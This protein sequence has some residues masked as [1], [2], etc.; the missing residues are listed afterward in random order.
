[1]DVEVDHSKRDLTRIA[2]ADADV[3]AGDHAIDQIVR[4]R[5]AGLVVNGEPAQDRRVAKPALEALRWHLDEVQWHVQPGMLAVPGL[6]EHFVERVAELVKKRAHILPCP[7]RRLIAHGRRKIADD[8]GD[9][10]LVAALGELAAADELKGREVRVLARPRMQVEVDGAQRAPSGRIANPRDLHV[11]GPFVDGSLDDDV[12][13]ERPF[14]QIEDPAQQGLLR[15]VLSHDL[16]VDGI[17]ALEHQIEII[18]DV[19]V[20]EIFD[21]K[22]GIVEFLAGDVTQPE[23]LGVEDPVDSSIE[24][25]DEALRHLGGLGHP[26]LDLIVGPGLVAE[27]FGDACAQLHD[28]QDRRGVLGHCSLHPGLQRP[29][30]SLA[31]G[32]VLHHGIELRLQRGPDQV[33]PGGRVSFERLQL[34]VAKTLE[35]LGLEHDEAL[36]GL[37]GEVDLGGQLGQSRAPV[38]DLRAILG[39]QHQTLAAII[40]EHVVE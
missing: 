12:E 2:M 39:A 24:I 13:R 7:Q 23:L 40:V 26:R 8:G 25:E 21:R 22:L 30:S 10:R 16:L 4:H 32:R 33:T 15:E 19:L 37:D 35:L 11:V 18:G 5:F 28:L 1:V 14:V 27:P 17:I 20:P 38:G 6:G 9:R 36:G 34:F 31:A 29:P 3:G